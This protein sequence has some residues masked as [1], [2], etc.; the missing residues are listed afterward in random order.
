MFFFTYPI[1]TPTGVGNG[2]GNGGRYG[3]GNG[4]V[5]G[6][7]NQGVGVG[8]DFD[9]SIWFKIQSRGWDPITLTGNDLWSHFNR[10]VTSDHFL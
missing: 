4:W 9:Y 2:V 3:V 1:P 7:G 6:V 10:W 8:N 5:Q